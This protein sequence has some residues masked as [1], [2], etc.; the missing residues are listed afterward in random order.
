MEG[1]KNTMEFEFIKSGDYEAFCFDVDKET[2]L[3]LRKN[4]GYENDSNF[5]DYADKSFFNKE[6]YRIYPDDLFRSNFTGRKKKKFRVKIEI[7]E[8]K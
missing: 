3:K 7:E 5:E 6:M 4:H 2:Y 8:V 1:Y